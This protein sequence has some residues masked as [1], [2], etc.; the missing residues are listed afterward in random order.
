MD[1][2]FSAVAM[3]TVVGLGA[4]FTMDLWGLFLNRVFNIPLSNYCLV[5][6]WLLYMPDGV[7]RHSSIV[8]AKQKQAECIIGWIAHYV[9]GVLFAWLLV[10]VVSPFWLRAPSLFPALV[11]GIVTVTLPFLVMQPAFGLGIAAAKTTNPNQARLRST[12][13]H[14]VFGVGLYIWAVISNFAVSY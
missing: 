8:A 2:D 14:A 11:F 5:G 6:R 1:L 9:T 13:N 12:M 10:M 4:T 7:F 3:A